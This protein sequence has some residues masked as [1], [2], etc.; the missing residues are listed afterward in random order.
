MALGDLVFVDSS[1]VAIQAFAEDGE[2]LMELQNV[3]QSA[4]ALIS[5]TITKTPQ[6]IIRA[7]AT[8][9]ESFTPSIP[10]KAWS[11]DVDLQL[12]VDGFQTG[13]VIVPILQK[14]IPPEA[15]KGQ[16]LLKVAFQAVKGTPSVANP[17][18]KIVVALDS[19]TPINPGDSSAEQTFTLRGGAYR[20][21]ED[22]KATF[23]KNDTTG[24]LKN[25]DAWPTKVS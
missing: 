17:V 2:D 9:G 14:V 15:T 25:S 7:R 19:H 24:A 22:P 16:W 20:Y 10:S 5:G 1:V 12:R 3:D 6:S 23:D 11:A 8:M 13:S 18:Y 4:S 21:I